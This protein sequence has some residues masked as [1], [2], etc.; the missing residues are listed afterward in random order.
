[1]RLLHQRRP[2][3]TA[4]WLDTT[5]RALTLPDCGATLLGLHLPAASGSTLVVTTAAGEARSVAPRAGWA[6]LPLPG[7]PLT[8]HAEGAPLRL[9]GGLGEGPEAPACRL[10]SGE[11]L[12]PEAH[13]RAARILGEG[14]VLALAGGAARPFVRLHA[15]GMARITLPPLALPGPVTPVLTALRGG[16]PLAELEGL[17]LTLRAGAFC[18]MLWDGVQ[19]RPNSL[20][21]SD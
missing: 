9:S 3:T 11:G 1:M 17:T 10:W 18:E 12:I 4:L 15:G 13:W 2:G 7:R 14:A 20:A 16:L 8:L 6:V 5:P 19:L 21:N